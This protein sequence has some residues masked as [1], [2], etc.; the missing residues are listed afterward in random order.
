MLRN[1][2]AQGC[3]STSVGNGLQEPGERSFGGIGSSTAVD[4]AN[5]VGLP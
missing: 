5:S 2:P 4:H 1:R 3:Q